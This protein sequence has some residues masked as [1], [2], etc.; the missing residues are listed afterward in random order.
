M[1]YQNTSTEKKV[2]GYVPYTRRQ[3]ML[4]P[5]GQELERQ[6]VYMHEESWAQLRDLC[7]EQRLGSSR[8]IALLVK[9]AHKVWCKDTLI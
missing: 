1:N 7:I 2:I 6:M 4:M 8:V 9:E 3:I 5:D